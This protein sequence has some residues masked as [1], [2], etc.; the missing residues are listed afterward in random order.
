MDGYHHD[1]HN[2]YLYRRYKEN[3]DPETI[4]DFKEKILNH[5]LTQ[6]DIDSVTVRLGDDISEIYGFTLPDKHERS[7]ER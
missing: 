5:T 1:G 7:F 4:E 2:C 6:K 3:A